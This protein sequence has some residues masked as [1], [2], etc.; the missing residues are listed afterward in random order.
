M[1]FSLLCLSGE[2]KEKGPVG[3]TGTVPS[4]ARLLKP[5]ANGWRW[6]RLVAGPNTK[7]GPAGGMSGH[8]V[9]CLLLLLQV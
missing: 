6:F 8:G 7:A 4:T 2:P 3:T 5:V 9:S 1:F